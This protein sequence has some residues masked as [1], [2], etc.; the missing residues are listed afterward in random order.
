MHVPVVF[1]L[2]TGAGAVAQPATRAPHNV[3]ITIQN[4][5]DGTLLLAQEVLSQVS[6]Q[7]LIP[8]AIAP[9]QTAQLVVENDATL[10]DTTYGE[11]RPA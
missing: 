9:G 3:E 7:S 11:I 4:A 8:V 10:N 1:T 5:T 2:S 6:T